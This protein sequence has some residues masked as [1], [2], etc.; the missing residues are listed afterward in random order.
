VYRVQGS[1]V[2]MNALEF[3]IQ[4]SEFRVLTLRSRIQVLGFRAK[5][6]GFNVQEL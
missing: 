5:G 6:I 1:G 3:L 4:C 2:I